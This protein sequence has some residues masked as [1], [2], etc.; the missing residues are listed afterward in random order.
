MRTH[1]VKASVRRH[2][3]LLFSTLGT[4]SIKVTK[5]VITAGPACKSGS[6]TVK[7]SAYHGL[8]TARTRVFRGS[9]QM[10]LSLELLLGRTSACLIKRYT[11]SARNI[12]CELQHLPKLP[13]RVNKRPRTDTFFDRVSRGF[14]H[15]WVNIPCKNLSPM[16]LAL[17]TRLALKLCLRLKAIR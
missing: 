5:P 12:F 4:H 3:A 11:M 17:A 8:V 1:C 14:Q 15:A 10:I 9:V 2:D 7:G 13:T 6:E 16:K